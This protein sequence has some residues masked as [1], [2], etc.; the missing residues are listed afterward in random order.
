M[1]RATHKKND[2]SEL[3]PQKVAPLITSGAGNG[4]LGSAIVPPRKVASSVQTTTQG[5]YALT[6]DSLENV[7]EFGLHPGG[8]FACSKFPQFTIQIRNRI[9]IQK[10]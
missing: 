8:S 3:E 1:G 5:G 9:C 10:N 7:S 6:S 4:P 2:G